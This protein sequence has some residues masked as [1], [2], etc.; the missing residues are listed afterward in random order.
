MWLQVVGGVPEVGQPGRLRPARSEGVVLVLQEYG[1]RQ[2]LD[3]E[4]RRD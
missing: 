4:S 3:R 2:S 1:G